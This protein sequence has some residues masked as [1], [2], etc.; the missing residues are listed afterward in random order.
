MSLGQSPIL[1]SA[2]TD[3]GDMT[4]PSPEPPP[5]VPDLMA[6]LTRIRAAI[7]RSR[8]PV[9]PGGDEVTADALFRLYARERAV[10]RRLRCRHRQWRAETGISDATP[11][12][13]RAGTSEADVSDQDARPARR[14]PRPGCGYPKASP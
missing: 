2:D 5:S 3:P 1:E 10:V 8:R 6:E 4:H 11:A 13:D 12:I 9:S 7:R 14:V